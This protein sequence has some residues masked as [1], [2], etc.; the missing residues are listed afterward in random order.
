[1]MEYARKMVLVPE[2]SLSLL[3]AQKSRHQ[4]H[5]ISDDNASGEKP[6][7]HL[8]TTTKTIEAALVRLDTEMKDILQSDTY[9]DARE[10][11][12]AYLAVLRRYLHFTTNERTLQSIE[13]SNIQKSEKNEEQSVTEP[14]RTGLNDSVI[15][16]SVPR[17]FRNKAKLLLRRL[18]D[19]P[20]AHF[21]WDT[22]GVV[23]IKGKPLKDSNIVDLINDAMRARKTAKPVGRKTF[24][25]FLRSIKTPREFIGNEALWMES[26]AN[27]T[28]RSPDL[29]AIQSDDSGDSPEI[30]SDH[31]EFYSGNES[32]RSN[33]GV[34][35]GSG[36]LCKKK[37][38]SWAR[39][40]L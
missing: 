14:V 40:K 27:S 23:S 29:Q 17:K 33:S 38:V 37:R 2:E 36:Y 8:S 6:R 19:T 34:Q 1:M 10:K 5:L 15:I 31:S 16:E 11:W 20:A 28:L 13:F 18:H 30:I 25:Q 9:K 39:I 3:G 24:A 4:A 35:N 7:K 22:D 32:N 26:T 21:S 12:N